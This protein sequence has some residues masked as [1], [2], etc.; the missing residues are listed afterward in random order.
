MADLGL[1]ELALRDRVERELDRVVAVHVVR[2][3]LDDGARPGLD[4]GHGRHRPG[5][6]IEDLAHAELL[7]EDALHLHL[8]A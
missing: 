4:H 5:V 6:G 3:H 2:A 1:R 7:A 8:I